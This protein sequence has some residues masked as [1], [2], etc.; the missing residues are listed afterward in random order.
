MTR[1]GM[2]RL[3]IE[4]GEYVTRSKN[5][6]IDIYRGTLNNGVTSHVKSG[7]FPLNPKKKG[8]FN[9]SR[10]GTDCLGSRGYPMNEP[11]Y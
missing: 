11:E 5:R 2:K 1:E 3:D 8:S 10:K 6:M 4:L 7:K 9:I